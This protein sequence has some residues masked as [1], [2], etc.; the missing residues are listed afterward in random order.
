MPGHPPQ[1]SPPR[2]KPCNPAAFRRLICTFTPETRNYPFLVTKM[3]MTNQNIPE[4]GKILI[5]IYVPTLIAKALQKK[6]PR[7]V[8][9]CFGL[10]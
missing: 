10:S 2:K 7:Y 9:V 5:G 3:T 4:K 1:V 6:A 8:R